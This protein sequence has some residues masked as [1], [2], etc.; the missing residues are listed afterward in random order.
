MEVSLSKITPSAGI[1]SLPLTLPDQAALPQKSFFLG[2][3]TGL[4]QQTVQFVVRYAQ[5]I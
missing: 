2:K 1:F 5:T 3:I 4:V